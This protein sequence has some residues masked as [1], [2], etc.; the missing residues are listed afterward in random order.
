[1]LYLEPVLEVEHISKTFIGQRVLNDVCLSIQPGEIHAL[2]G[3]NGSGKSTLIKCLSGYYEPDAGASIR[4]SGQPIQIPF[5]PDQINRAGMR[6]VHQ[7]LGIVPQ[8]TVTENL[9]LGHGFVRGRLGNIR[10]RAERAHAVDVLKRVGC[11]DVLPTSR[12]SSLSTAMQTMV[13]IGRAVRGST[14]PASVIILDEPSASLPQN[15]VR[16]LHD[17]IRRVAAS[18]TGILLVSHRLSEV[19]ELASRATVLRDGSVVGTFD[20]SQLDHDSLAE[21]IVGRKFMV[22]LDSSLASQTLSRRQMALTAR[23]VSGGKVEGFD[24]DLHKGEIVGLAGLRGSGRST[25]ARLLAGVEEKT[26][27]TVAVLGEEVPSGGIRAALT[28][29]IIY[30]SE[31]RKGSSIVPSM[32]VGENLLLPRLSSFTRFWGLRKRRI[33]AAAMQMIDEYGVCPPNPDL[34]MKLLSGGNQQK[35]VLA[36]WLSVDPVVALL[37]EPVQGIDIGAK[38]EIFQIIVAAAARSV[39]VV[40]IDSDLENLS[41]LCHRILVLHNG[42]VAEELTGERARDSDQITR[43]VLL[44]NLTH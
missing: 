7:D 25:I 14:K 28:K 8:L 11:A 30:V 40:V 9:G 5:V 41:R 23:R 1:M 27:G 21:L 34:T 19:F 10:W 32:S 39:A 42:I 15:D 12:A 36:R 13:A 26:A 16:T 43:S 2:V 22:D 31:D 17:A 24:F 18:G 20:V 6:F 3:Q 29:G 37:D 4:V 38:A 33:R 44:A 35:V